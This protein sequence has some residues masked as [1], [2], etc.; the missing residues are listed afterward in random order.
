MIL[1]FLEN[2]VG[3]DSQE[4]EVRDLHEAQIQISRQIQF[5]VPGGHEHRQLLS[6]L[7][8]QEFASN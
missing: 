1:M 6:L 3:T 4:I 7:V 5:Y 8:L 2:T